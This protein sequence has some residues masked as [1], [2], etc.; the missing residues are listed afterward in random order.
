MTDSA[1]KEKQAELDALQTAFDEYIASSRELEEELDAELTKCQQDLDQAESRNSAL[2]SQL[3]NVT[4]Q[5]NSLETKLS[6][7][8]S[9]LKQ[10]SQRRIQ[11]EMTCEEA[12]NKLREAEGALASVQQSELRKL[13][14]ENEDLYERLAFIEGESED[15]RNE[16]ETERERHRGELEEMKEDLD[17]MKMKLQEKERE[18]EESK[19][20]NNSVTI[21]NSE[22]QDDTNGT[23]NA[24]DAENTDGSAPNEDDSFDDDAF[25]PTAA[26]STFD[27]DD[28][29][30]NVEDEPTTEKENINDDDI[31]EL[32]ET[33]P[34]TPV[35]S[36][37][38]T[39]AESPE[40]DKQV[41]I[42]TLEDE[43]EQYC[44][45]LIEAEKKLSQTQADLEEALIEAEEANQQLEA[46]GEEHGA[47]EE[48]L[49]KAHEE[50][51]A[52]LESV[53][54]NLREE[55][56][57]LE[58]ECKRLKEQLE[59]EIEAYEEDVRI[60]ST[61]LETSQKEHA[62][63]I[64]NL[65][66]ELDKI[67][68]ESRSRDIES[69][70]W[71]EAMKASKKETQD[72]Q[73]EVERL[74]MALKNSKSD[75]EVLQGEMDE[76]TQA[77]DETATREKQ[78]S[79]GQHEAL[80]ELL[81]TRSREVEELKE[82]MNNL[83]ETNSSLTKLLKDAEE[84]MEKEHAAN[85]RQ[86]Q[87]VAN[88]SAS[89]STELSAAKHEIKSLEASL[90][91]VRT[92]LTAQQNEVE[93]VRSSLEEKISY[94]QKELETAE[95]ELEAT[96][97][98][99]AEMETKQVELT[100]RRKKSMHAEGQGEGQS[101]SERTRSLQDECDRLEDQNRMS[102]SMKI[103]L[104]EEIK[105]LKNQLAA[106]TNGRQSG[107]DSVEEENEPTADLHGT[108][109]NIEEILQSNN[110]DMIADEFR[111][112]AKRVS[113]QKTHNAELL[114]RILKLQGNIQVCC[115][116]RPMSIG[117]SQKGLHEVAQSLSETEVG[118]F[119]ER[120]Q[121]WK[122]YAF[123]KVWGPETKQNDVF[124]DVEPMAMSVIDGYNA[125]IFAYGQTGSGKT[126]TMEGDK[127]R[128]G[129]SQRTINKIFVLLQDR[130]REKQK[131][132]VAHG[133]ESQTKSFEYEIEV[134]MLEIYNDEVYD[135]LDSNFSSNQSSPQKRSLDVRHGGDNVVEVPGLRKERVSS[136][137]D[138]LHALDRGNAN[139]AKASTNLNEH[140]SRSHMILR[141]DV[142]SGVGEAKN[143]GTLYLV[144]L[145]G[146]ERVRKSE[147]EGK[148]LKE[149]QYINKSLS[150]L[151]NV[152]EALDRK[153][154][155][156]P[157]RDSKLTHLLQNSLGGNS[158]TMMV[159]TV[160]PHNDSYDETTFA[161]K[162]ATRVRRINLGSAQKNVVAKNLEE[163]VKNLTSEL[164]AISK[165]K[166]RSE[167]QLM[168][169]KREKERVEEKLVKASVS[170][171]NSKGEIKTLN[172]LKQTND[173]ITARWQKEKIAREDT[174][175][176]LE[177]S[178]ES[179]RKVQKDLSSLKHKQDTL[180]RQN[181][182]K[183]NI[184]FDLKKNLRSVKEQLNEEKIRHRRATVMQ[185]RIPA[186]SARTQSARKTDDANKESPYMQP[187]TGL[188]R[189]STRSQSA[190]KAEPPPTAVPDS[191]SVARI[192]FRVLKMLQEHDPAKADKIDVVMNK[193]KGRET[194]LLEKMIARYDAKV[195][196]DD[197]EVTD[198]A[199]ST[200]S[201]TENDSSDGRPKSRQDVALERHMARMKRIREA[202]GLS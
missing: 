194:E 136:V 86:Q 81:A 21:A 191:N 172:L 130:A 34:S 157:Y 146:S 145:A 41:Y 187:L 54:A 19:N 135:L 30:P 125:C 1:V 168:S 20:N 92:E 196:D 73:E 170:R 193:F 27:E 181:E 64:A 15:Y 192:R 158:R 201:S 17:V 29:L 59:K 161:L 195:K 8:T 7:V 182:D 14:E 38:V 199:E 124:H 117:E 84:K 75:F 47:L 186:P 70:E 74:E 43:L 175:A 137:S 23:E 13:K 113:T 91:E 52:E 67:T 150:A 65:R 102:V 96:R 189:P 153:S 115:R 58:N 144:D 177:K 100:P 82:E 116:I 110:P 62:E 149:A 129:I 12:E 71:E 2:A 55:N 139:R 127:E 68:S 44:D 173:D 179:L 159:V 163:S 185:S 87:E 112:L 11:A 72:L 48:E 26:T 174:A 3:A 202:K 123:D 121:S 183:E 88:E 162:F 120:T 32:G 28:F 152:M 140:S 24:D 85:E 118:C 76:L 16:L 178:Q 106:A 97:S 190:K 31:F 51:V 90:D 9:Q 131:Q 40:D 77:F 122:S 18:L 50:K 108:E 107:V 166:E 169:L 83:A 109:D 143:K 25:L 49:I 5:L 155:H 36:E 176:E 180:I 37:S 80:K 128:H 4:P 79:D 184:I 188:K 66:G 56:D 35:E 98:K 138:V 39:P 22:R 164:H 93:K 33:A 171:A 95:G 165:A 46:M 105:Q 141:V 200:T 198:V 57:A 99:L 167:S 151:G 132:L 53:I 148:E 154:S 142:T 147:V 101:E 103:H 126:Y 160:C 89:S 61:K 10:E 197:E 45:Q 42:K 134:G 69:K 133:E 104:E 119:D 63:E 111:S 94:V 78:E 6:S 114:T 156:V 60:K